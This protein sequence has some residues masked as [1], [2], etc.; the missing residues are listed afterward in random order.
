VGDLILIVSEEG[1][2]TF[3]VAGIGFKEVDE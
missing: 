3:R 1:S 2:R